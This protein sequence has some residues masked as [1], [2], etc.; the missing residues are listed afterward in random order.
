[1]SETFGSLCKLPPI[2]SAVIGQLRVA[3]RGQQQLDE[4]HVPTSCSK[5]HNLHTTEDFQEDSSIEFP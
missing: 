1:M 5:T 4:F 3:T 2:V